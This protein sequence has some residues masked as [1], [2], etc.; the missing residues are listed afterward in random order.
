MQRYYEFYGVQLYRLI[1]FYKV[2]FLFDCQLIYSFNFIV[3]NEGLYIEVNIYIWYFSL[4]Y[5]I[6]IVEINYKVWFNKRQGK[7]FFK[8]V[9]IGVKF[10]LYIEVIIYIG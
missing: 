5:F 2:S 10:I 6:Y 8:V 3:Y 7:I 1:F 4:S 9:F